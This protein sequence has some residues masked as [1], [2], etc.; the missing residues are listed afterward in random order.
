MQYK[1]FKLK[2]SRF[3]RPGRIFKSFRLEYFEKNF[4]Q[5]Y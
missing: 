4:H 1:K 2:K 5:S 3:T